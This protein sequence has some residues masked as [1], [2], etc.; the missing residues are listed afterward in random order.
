[1]ES[2]HWIQRLKLLPHPEGGFFRE[3]YRSSVSVPP[4]GLPP[5]FLGSRPF[6]TAIYYLLEGTDFSAFH[7][8]RSD[9]IWHFYD[10]NPLS[11]YEI[12]SDGV[13]HR[14][15]LGRHAE[16][17]LTHVVPAGTW[18]AARLDEGKGM[19]LSGCTVSPGFD[20][21][22]FEMAD[23]ALLVSAYPGQ[24]ALIRELTRAPS[25]S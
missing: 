21:A 8:I 1:M 2:Q 22:D 25:A 15:V 3:F 24:E 18:F 13:L 9:E 17:V 11:I 5:G 16:G 12:D 20:F 10:G 23:P 19:A 14:T 6:S 7:R 4:G